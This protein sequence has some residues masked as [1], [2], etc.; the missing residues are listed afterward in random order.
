MASFWAIWI[1]FGGSLILEMVYRFTT[2]RELQTVLQ[3]TGKA[4][5]K[6]I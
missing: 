3:R 1:T 4:L 2:G 5:H 6:K